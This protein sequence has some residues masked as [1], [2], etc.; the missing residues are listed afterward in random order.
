MVK[1]IHLFDTI[2][3]I[4]VVDITGLGTFVVD[5][6]VSGIFVF[7]K[8][9]LGVSALI[10]FATLILSACSLNYD[11]INKKNS[12]TGSSNDFERSVYR[13][14]THRTYYLSYFSSLSILNSNRFTP[15]NAITISNIKL[16]NTLRIRYSSKSVK[17][18]IDYILDWVNLADLLFLNHRFDTISNGFKVY[19]FII[20]SEG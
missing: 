11:Q 7:G 6:I 9:S 20:N 4:F 10:E 1:I 8:F 15:I 12:M 16:S 17:I 5:I 14:S 2:F 3:G 18:P 13:R 19:G